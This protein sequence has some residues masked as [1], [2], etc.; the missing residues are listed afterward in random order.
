MRRANGAGGLSRGGGRL[1]LASSRGQRKGGASAHGRS[2]FK[3]ALGINSRSRGAFRA[4]AM[5]ISRPLRE[6]AQGRPGAGCTHGP[7]AAKNAGGSHHRY[8]PDS[9]PSLRDG[10]NGLLRALPRDRLSCPCIATTRKSAR[11]ARPQHREARTTRLD[12]RID[13][14]RPLGKTQAAASTRPPHP[15]LN[16]RDDRE[17]PL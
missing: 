15:A 10:L 6:R 13:A 17:A 11:C 9:R 2:A 8:E 16:V 7:P 14:V 12:R 5:P 3:T 1:H 4:R